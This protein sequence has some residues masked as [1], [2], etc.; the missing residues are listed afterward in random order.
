MSIREIDLS[1]EIKRLKKEM[2]IREIDLSEEIKKFEE[3]DFEV[4]KELTF[5]QKI[6][7]YKEYLVVDFG[8]ILL[9][10]REIQISLNYNKGL[11]TLSSS[12]IADLRENREVKP[13][14]DL[15]QALLKTGEIQTLPSD[16]TL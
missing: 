11:L 12:Q 4:F 10:L 8:E 6:A 9:P 15:L 7:I 3:F 14:Y 2:S 5:R 1:E 16:L 13:L